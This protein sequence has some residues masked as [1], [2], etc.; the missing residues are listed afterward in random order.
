VLPR[1]AG[2]SRLSAFGTDYIDE[3]GNSIPVDEVTPGTKVNRPEPLVEIVRRCC[4]RAV[5]RYANPNV[6]I[7]GFLKKP[8]G[9][10]AATQ[11]LLIDP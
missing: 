8:I 11:I 6:R 9:W 10:S 1:T 2:Q 4:S 7:A 5:H 3:F